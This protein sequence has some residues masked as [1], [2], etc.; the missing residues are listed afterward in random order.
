MNV[1]VPHEKDFNVY[2]DEIINHSSCNFIFGKLN[3]YKS[4]YNIVNIQFPEA[5]FNWK[6]PSKMQLKILEKHIIKWRQKSKIILTFNDAKSHYDTESKF[7][8]LFKLIQKYTDGVIHLGNFSLN[9]YKHLFQKKCKHALI[10]HPLY[11]S[12]LNIKTE[13]IED[14]IDKKFQNKFV[15]SVIGN[16]R[17]LEE[18]KL[19]F[20]IFKKIPKKNKFL[21]IPKMFYFLKLPKRFPYRYRRIFWSLKEKLFCYPLLKKQYYF[22]YNYINYP[23]MA[24]LVKKTDVLII[25]RLKNLNSGI[26]FLGLTFNKPMVIPK[27]GN[28]TEIAEDLNLPLLDLETS[29]YKETLQIITSKAFKESLKSPKYL[30]KKRAYNPDKIAKD[31]ESFFNAVIYN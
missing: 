21:V 11:E 25:P 23:L 13:N 30:A 1:F 6:S 4:T 15:V 19:I 3:N 31:Y 9:T 29:N 22:G 10:Y 18:A 28:L 24:D 17:S 27:I 16:V 8:D 5:I 7:I 12:L 14:K 2:F 26:L 20:K